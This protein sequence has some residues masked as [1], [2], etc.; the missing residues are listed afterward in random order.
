MSVKFKF[1]KYVIV[2]LQ[3]S[4]IKYF[5]SVSCVFLLTDRD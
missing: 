3:L 1:Q 4:K 2:A 5:L